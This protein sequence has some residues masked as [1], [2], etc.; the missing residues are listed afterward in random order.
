M[1]YFNG[2]S[3]QQQCMVYQFTVSYLFYPIMLPDCSP[4]P[5]FAKSKQT[6]L[7]AQ[8]CYTQQQESKA[9]QSA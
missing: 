2:I 4:R 3:L 8:D 5:S 6:Q 1:K 9:Q 7:G